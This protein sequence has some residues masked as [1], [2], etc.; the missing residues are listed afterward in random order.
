MSDL[1]LIERAVSAA[2]ARDDETLAELLSPHF[3]ARLASGRIIIGEAG[4]VEAVSYG[5][6]VSTPAADAFHD[7]E[8]LGEGFVLSYEHRPGA[9]ALEP[10]AW[11]IHVRDLRL[12]ALIHFPSAE[13][14]VESLPPHMR[15][16]PA[17]ELVA[18]AIA[19]SNTRDMS[20]LVEM[21][22]GDFEVVPAA[23]AKP[24][25][26]IPALLDMQE[27]IAERFDRYELIPDRIE[28]LGDGFVLVEGRLETSSAGVENTSP[29]A[30]LARVQNGLA[31]GWRLF[32][33][34]EQ[35]R[36]AA[37]RRLG[38]DSN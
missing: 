2:R 10:G 32:D 4:F 22:A 28:Y 38:E 8:Q 23:G 36:A 15:D 20:A 25:R 24:L 27:M 14:A 3:F 35:A 12:D 13:A 7:L 31:T 18:R 5:T 30:I 34:A 21:L 9:S 19:A 29:R 17:T 37:G 26:G 16:L 1:A 6:V 33:S 11:L